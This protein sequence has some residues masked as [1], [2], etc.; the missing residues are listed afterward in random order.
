MS[1]PKSSCAS[2]SDA[3]ETEAWSSHWDLGKS[4]RMDQQ[5]HNNPFTGVDAQQGKVLLL[6]KGWESLGQEM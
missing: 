2:F 1:L 6:W 4:A 5:P 3:V